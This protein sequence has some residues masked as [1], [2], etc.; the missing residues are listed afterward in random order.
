MQPWEEKEQKK[1]VKYLTVYYDIETDQSSPVPG[2][3]NT[4]EH[5]PNLLVSHTVCDQCRNVT[6]NDYFCTVCRNR[7]NI[8]HNLDDPSLNVMSQFFDYLQSF[9]GKYE[10]LLVAHNAKSFDG[11]FALQEVIARKMK[12]ELILQ[13]A[14]IICMKVGSWKFIDSLMFLT[15]PLSAMPKSFG[16]SELKKGYWPFLANTPEYYNYEGPMLGKEYYCVSTMKTKAALEFDKW[17]NEQVAQNYVF[18]FRRELIDYCVSDVTIL[19]QGC[20]AFRTLF[21]ELAGFDPMMHCITLSAA[22]M[23]TYRRNFLPEG[24]IGLVPDGGYHGRGKQSH[25]ALKWLDYESHKLGKVIKTIY[26]D[27]EVSVMGRRVDGYVELEQPD[28]SV[29]KRIYQFH[30]CYWHQC[31]KHFPTTEDDVINRY[32]QTV[33][34]TSLF[35]R[36]GYTVI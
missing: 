9:K 33:R 8:F 10:I 23:A 5:K 1:D 21:T 35:R 36:G 13:G 30:G 19:R 31:P 29:E 22:C 20:T 4:F 16:L 2:L 3:Q 17:Y 34:I 12:P 7:Q 28:G 27:R 15:M 6:H 11:I 18:N 25:V 26:T 24:K 32:E 14:K